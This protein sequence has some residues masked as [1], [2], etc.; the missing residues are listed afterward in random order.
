MDL[1]VTPDY[2]AL[3]RKAADLVAATVAA[4]PNC[5]VVLPTGDTP[6]GLYRELIDRRARGEFDPSGLRIFQLDEYLGLAPNDPPSFYRWLAKSFLDPLRIPEGNV[7]RF[8]S[9]S[10]EPDAACRDYEEEV[11]AAGGYD[12]AVLGLGANGHLG[13][14]EPPANPHLPTRVVPLRRETIETNAR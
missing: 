4:R 13:F 12:L 14:N 2:E 8:A 3:S 10:P 7:V 11:R 9:S 1:I 6:M 5:N